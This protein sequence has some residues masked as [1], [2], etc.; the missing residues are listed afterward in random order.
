M[1]GVFDEAGDAPPPPDRSASAPSAP[2]LPASG[3]GRFAFFALIPSLLLPGVVTASALLGPAGQDGGFGPIGGLVVGAFCLVL[4][5][6]M[7]LNAWLLLRHPE[8]WRLRAYP[9]GVAIGLVVLWALL[10]VAAIVVAVLPLEL[11]AF[12]LGV[13]IMIVSIVVFVA[14]VARTRV[15]SAVAPVVAV[16]LSRYAIVLAIGFFVV[17][18]W[19]VISAVPS[20]MT[21]GTL[22]VL[23]QLVIAGLPWSWPLTV[24]GL[25]L[26]QFGLIL[27]FGVLI[28]AAVVVNT[29]IVVLLLARP[30]FR[31]R[32]V[33]W[34][35]KLKGDANDPTSIRTLAPPSE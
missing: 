2:A 12:I 7:T 15:K 10:V 11:Y 27:V 13:P 14:A 4:L 31:T 5:G 30:A 16:G 6:S 18:A 20:W 3:I 33:N 17:V 35:F 21:A 32:F 24:L 22:P 9:R 1:T 34:F 25:L 23:F 19:A 26:N 8:T 28:L 29:V